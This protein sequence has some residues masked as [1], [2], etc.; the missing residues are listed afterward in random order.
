MMV[1]E[2]WEV[3][4]LRLVEQFRIAGADDPEGWA[5]S[6][7]S[8]DIP[9]LARF[10]FLRSVWPH[11]IDRRRQQTDWIDDAISRAERDPKGYFADAGMAI[12]EAL[13]HGITRDELASIARMIAYETAFDMVHRIDVGEDEEYNPDNGYPAWT[14]SEVG[15][16]EEPTGRALDALHEDLLSIDPSGREGSPQ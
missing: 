8:E 5:R 16:D 7:I 15:S 4:Y 1:P 10:C 12:K 11:V 9:Q 13:A 6:E 3:E 14:L 2:G